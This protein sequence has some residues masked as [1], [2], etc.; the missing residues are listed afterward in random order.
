MPEGDTV[1]ATAARL[2][3]A[4]DGRRLE[5]TQ[6]R[7]PSLAT[8]DLTGRTVGSVR[9]VGKHLLIDVGGPDD[10]QPDAGGASVHSHLKMEGAWHVHPIGTRWRRPGYQARIVLRTATHEAVG[11]DLGILELTDSPDADLA[12]LGPDLL[13]EDWEPTEAI[14]RIE[15]RPDEPIGLALLDQRLVAGIGNVYRSEICFLRKVLP[16]RPVRDVDVP[17]VVD[18]SRRLLWANR[19]RTARTTTGQSAPN[20]RMWVYGRRGQLCRRCGSPIERDQLG[21]IGEDRVIYFCPHCQT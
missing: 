10:D 2:R 9:S 17:G 18:L 11:F 13:A 6:F 7:V 3:A 15:A 21:S 12:Y 19:L 20:A 5:W 4:L 14:G 16:T 1:F 8:V